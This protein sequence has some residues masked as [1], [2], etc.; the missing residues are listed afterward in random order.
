MPRTK[1]PGANRLLQFVRHLRS[2]GDE[3]RGAIAAEFMPLKGSENPVETKAASPQ[4]SKVTT[5]P[6][7]EGG[8]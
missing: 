4:K 3:K 1:R 7:T 6:T 5:G 2:A 8:D